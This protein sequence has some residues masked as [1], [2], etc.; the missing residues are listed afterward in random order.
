ME[1]IV[2]L[3]YGAEM[4]NSVEL[5][6]GEMEEARRA[7]ELFAPVN[8]P[9]IKEVKNWIREHNRGSVAPP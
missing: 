9:G 6:E 7:G 1:E 5:S 4:A 2:V 3:C 8:V